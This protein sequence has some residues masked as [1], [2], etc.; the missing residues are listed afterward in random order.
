MTKWSWFWLFCAVV[1]YFGSASYYAEV[2][3]PNISKNPLFYFSFISLAGLLIALKMEKNY[4]STLLFVLT[5][6]LGLVFLS[7]YLG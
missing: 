7:N 6:V 2:V 5:L 1:L 4:K 3:E